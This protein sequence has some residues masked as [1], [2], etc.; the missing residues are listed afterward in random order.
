MKLATDSEIF[1]YDGTRIVSAIGKLGTKTIGEVSIEEDN[2]LAEFQTEPTENRAVF[3]R[4]VNAG[5]QAIKDES[6]MDVKI[7]ASHTFTKEYLKGLPPKAYVFGCNI[8]M[9]AYTDKSNPKPNAYTNQRTSGG[10][11]H[12]D[13]PGK[14]MS[15]RRTKLVKLLDLYLGVPSVLLDSDGAKR[16]RMYGKAGSYRDKSYG[17]E[18][19]VLSNF[20]LRSDKLI[21]WVFDQTAIAVSDSRYTQHIPYRRARQCIDECDRVLAS[22]L[23]SQF[24]LQLP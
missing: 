8:D 14:R 15:E 18:Y 3:I 1:L 4:R 7:Q 16:R 13:V 6:G 23:V 20:W 9:N 19:R 17:I 22:K 5:I 21:G 2:I 12:I 10:H 24:N 11:L